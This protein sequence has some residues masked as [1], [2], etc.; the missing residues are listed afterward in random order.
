MLILLNIRP[1]RIWAVCFL[2]SWWQHCYTISA[3]VKTKRTSIIIYWPKYPWWGDTTLNSTVEE[4]AGFLLLSCSAGARYHCLILKL[5]VVVH[6]EQMRRHTS[7]LMSG[8]NTTGG[9]HARTPT[10]MRSVVVGHSALHSTFFTT[11][12]SR[13]AVMSRMMLSHAGPLDSICMK[14]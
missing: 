9:R 4:E 12:G 8:R 13:L 3:Q 14:T 10:C 1:L 11:S 7:A 5:H 2:T 6:S